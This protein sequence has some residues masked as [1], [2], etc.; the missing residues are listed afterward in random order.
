MRNDCI[1]VRLARCT[2]SHNTSPAT[3]LLT[4]P[5]SGDPT[6]NFKLSKEADSLLESQALIVKE[7]AEKG[8]KL[9]SFV[10]ANLAVSWGGAKG[11]LKH[12][13]VAVG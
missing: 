9:P 8:Q 5:Q 11:N 10:H 1:Y 2:T 4:E 12:N 13:V 7:M 3:G 6:E